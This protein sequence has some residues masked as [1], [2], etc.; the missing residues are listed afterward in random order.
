MDTAV[1]KLK[2]MMKKEPKK[3]DEYMNTIRE[4]RTKAIDLINNYNE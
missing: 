1:A 3:A 4:L 2:T